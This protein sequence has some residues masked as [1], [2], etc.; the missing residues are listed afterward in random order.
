M[1]KPLLDAVF[2]SEKR[3]STLLLL[4]AGPK[5]MA[6][7][8]QS[9]ETTRQSLLPQIRILEEHHLVTSSNDIYELTTIGKLVV[10]EMLPLLQTIEVFD[11]DIDYW[12]TRNLDFIPPH[13]LAKIDELKNCEIINPPITELYSFHK[14]F[15]PDFEVSSTA[16]TITGFLNPNFN[17]IFAE[18]LENGMNVHFIVSQDLFNKIRKE[19]R[20]E[21]AKLI[22]N[23]SFNLYVYNK[24][25]KFL[26]FSFD[27]IHFVLSLLTSKGEFDHKFVVCKSKSAVQWIKELFEHCLKDSTPITEI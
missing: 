27:D 3:K 18:M 22:E 23:M 7:L 12:G 17:E 14:S 6:T 25:M 11:Y 20:E 16:Y 24:E 5:E 15:N 26:F 1:K 21:F 13:L 2:A 10:D 4:Q 8:L 19:H 9:L